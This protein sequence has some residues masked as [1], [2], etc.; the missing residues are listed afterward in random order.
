MADQTG[1]KFTISG[2]ADQ[3]AAAAKQAIA[4]VN[5]MEAAAERSR[6]V[7]A[8]TAAW[9][10]EMQ[11]IA[12][13]E[14]QQ[15]FAQLGIE[16]QLA[17]LYERRAATAA[18]I[19]RS[20]GNE[21]R[22]TALKLSQAR[23]QQQIGELE[24][25]RTEAIQRRNASIP[26]RTS[27]GLLS[28]IAGGVGRVGS[29]AA[30]G[31][32]SGLGLG[33]AGGIAGV[34][35][36]ATLAARQVADY[37]G[38]IGDLSK[39]TGISTSSLQEWDY[40]AKQSG[41][42]L[43]NVTAAVRNLQVNQTQA[44]RGSKAEV[45]AFAAL[46]IS[47]DDLKKK[48]SEELFLALAQNIGKAAPSAQQTANVLTVLGRSADALLPAFRD[49]FADAA[50]SARDLGIVIDEEV[51]GSLDELGDRWDAVLGQLKSSF[52]A[53]LG[54]VAPML[55]KLAGE[56]VA[57]IAFLRS[58]FSGAGW[59]KATLAGLEARN[60]LE[61]L[62]AEKPKAPLAPDEAGLPTP[63]A[64]KSKKATRS[65]TGQVSV[66]S[67]PTADAMARIGLFVGAHDPNRTLWQNQLTEL[68][69][70]V[71]ELKVLNRSVTAE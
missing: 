43:G 3:L 64:E 33:V 9:R 34:A 24:I 47:L 19:E 69:K 57:T 2:D 63:E 65:G 55:N 4:Q 5:A 51:I 1:I 23:T 27:G 37:A 44:L 66:G 59:E 58:Y 60:K 45:A 71:S 49:G 22:T 26:P 67:L 40:A 20:S 30:E 54:E 15:K 11:S 13:Q 53:L 62:G 38:M 10:R 68:R 31:L 52:A 8:T 28:R 17:I 12:R 56:M 70:M 32:M 18:R 46:G 7:Q 39:R 41:A 36:A 16:Q 6:R 21:V 50:A 48:G 14:A 61:R 29:S 25:R 42:D 35:A